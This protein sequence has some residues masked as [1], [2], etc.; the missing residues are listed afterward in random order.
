MIMH[1]EANY[2]EH[3]DNTINGNPLI[4]CLHPLLDED[5]IKQRL[6]F[7]PTYADNF[8]DLNPFYKA[9]N[10]RRLW[11]VYVPSDLSVTLYWKFF[12][13]ILDGYRYRNPLTAAMARFIDLLAEEE[14]K[15]D[16]N[17]LSVPP[18]MTIAPGSVVAGPSGSG[19]TSGVR[20]ALKLIPQVILHTKYKHHH[21]FYLEQLVWTSFDCPPSGSMK[22]L[23]LNF[24][25]SV[26]D[27]L[28]TKYFST[29][30]K[31]RNNYTIEAY[32]VGAQ[33]IAANHYIGLVH[34]D[35]LQFMLKYKSETAPDLIKLEALFNK[36]GV[37][38]ITS[39]TTEGL[40]LFDLDTTSARRMMSERVFKIQP[41][42]FG[43]NYS[44]IF[45]DALFPFELW[46]GDIQ[47]HP[48]FLEEFFNITA[49]LQAVMVRL[50]RLQLDFCVKKGISP[51][52]LN[53]LNRVFMSQF[54]KIQPALLLL[55]VNNLKGFEEKFSSEHLPETISEETIKGQRGP[56][57]TIRSEPE[58][59]P[60]SAFSVKSTEPF[61][62]ELIGLDDT[63]ARK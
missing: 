10:I 63:A 7:N 38:I 2:R 21:D 32:I 6:T 58:P 61:A 24:M 55:K 13:Y 52:D 19:K 48:H 60:V 29:W 28:N 44:K 56:A 40:D 9:L 51:F 37:P 27:A 26:D 17:Y 43:S 3:P 36:I 16:K 30:D 33:I 62:P 42:K 31:R 22:D 4:E 20:G 34:I 25:K 5:E 54:E 8:N 49:G 57:E 23:V 12:E 14:R 15:E 39:T 35:E 50:A 41:I 45:C 46:G 53:S 18:G 47:Q 1:E 11:E 59:A